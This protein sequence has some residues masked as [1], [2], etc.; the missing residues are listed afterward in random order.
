MSEYIPVRF[1]H[2]L[3]FAGIGAVVRAEDGLYTVIDSSKWSGHHFLPYVERVRLS[4]GIDQELHEPPKGK[5]DKNGRV[6]GTTVPGIRFPSWMRCRACGLMHWQWWKQPYA[7]NVG[8]ICVHCGKPLEQFPW[9]MIDTDGRMDD[10]PWHWLLHRG[11]S[12]KEDRRSPH[13]TLIDNR[14]A[15]SSMPT[16]DGA[17][18]TSKR[19]TLRCENC[20]PCHE[21]KPCRNCD[22]C[23]DCKHPRHLDEREAEH[24]GLSFIRHQPWRPDNPGGDGSTAE[25]HVV[26]VS[27]P[28]LYSVPPCSALV[29]PP[30]SRVRRGSVLDRLYCN[31][32]QLSPI[33]SAHN[34]NGAI[35]Q[36][37]SALNCSVK[38]V[39]DALQEIQGGYPLYGQVFTPGQLLGDEYRAITTPFDPAEDE[40]FVTFHRTAQWRELGDC[41]ADRRP[42]VALVS[43]LIE[44]KRL[45]EVRVF[46]GF[47][48]VGGE[49]VV[50]PDVDGL[51]NWL[52]AIDLFGEGVFFSID[53]SILKP[54]ERQ[55]GFKARLDTLQRRYAPSGLSNHNEIW[56]PGG[57]ITARFMLLHTLAHLLIRQVEASAGYPAASLKERLYCGP[58]MA[59]ILIYVAVPDIAGSLGGL[60]E[61]ST[62]K[63]FLTLLNAAL[64]KADWCSLD[65]VCSEHEG[66]GPHLLNF[67]ACH[68]CALIPEP[69]CLFGNELLDRTFV[70]G[71]DGHGIVGI[72]DYAEKY[73]DGAGS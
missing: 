12:C 72:V 31:R 68:G 54:W 30:E 24:A 11:D 52:P 42:Q 25:I 63:R 58:D 1:S 56:L 22:K 34:P 65:P 38:E 51:V 49:A 27:D 16:A 19:W 59:G 8:P 47:T 50:P 9:V 45:R 55:A 66:Q 29:I 13:L 15:V 5:V 39:R 36:A 23:R 57:R 21:T 10:V 37:A 44:L 33:L 70:K 35:R 67:A 48:R 14:S 28:R 43:Q 64:A 46:K 41:M 71:D 61:L 73:L 40:D 3:G 7:P 62:P 17:S 53:E 6:Q 60:S 32:S 4:L 26:D 2:L 20:K 69:S 18:G